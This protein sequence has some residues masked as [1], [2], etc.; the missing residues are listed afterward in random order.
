MLALVCKN[1]DGV[2]AMESC[3]IEGAINRNSGL[4]GLG[5]SVGHTIDGRFLVI[6]LGHL[7]YVVSYFICYP[8]TGF[9]F[10]LMFIFFFLISLSLINISDHMLAS[11]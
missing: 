7:R 3:D 9:S 8:F 5:S 2:Q 6:C 10:F 4:H 11:L 1:F